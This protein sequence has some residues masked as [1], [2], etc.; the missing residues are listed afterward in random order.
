[1]SLD[2]A[3]EITSRGPTGR[4]PEHGADIRQHKLTAGRGVFPLR[5]LRR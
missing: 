1:M 4:A 5:H 3:A 2:E